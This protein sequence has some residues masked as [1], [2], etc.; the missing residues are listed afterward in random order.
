MA[1]SNPVLYAIQNLQSGRNSGVFSAV[2]SVQKANANTM[3]VM[4]E[5]ASIAPQVQVAQE[6]LNS[7][8]PTYDALIES[9]QAQVPA[10]AQG[11]GAA[12]ASARG[13]QAT[14]DYYTGLLQQDTK[15]NGTYQKLRGEAQAK[16][17][18]K[19]SPWLQQEAAIKQQQADG[20]TAY[21]GDSKAVMDSLAEKKTRLASSGYLAFA[22][23]DEDTAT[24]SPTGDSLASTDLYSDS[25]ATQMGAKKAEQ[26][27]TPDAPE[28]DILSGV[29]QSS[30]Y[31]R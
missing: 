12:Y 21:V 18:A 7:R 9:L 24:P 6:G 19:I 15:Y 10:V 28:E 5:I 31:S 14:V 26:Q 11:K 25:L 3:G 16:V 27:A 23:P 20:Y 29:M 17:E 22:A 30:L 1:S 2:R 4:E 8:K 13:D